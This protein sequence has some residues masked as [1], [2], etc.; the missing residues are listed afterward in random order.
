MTI[1]ILW[2]IIGLL[3]IIAIHFG[4]LAWLNPSIELETLI[5]VFFTAAYGFYV[6]YLFVEP[7]LRK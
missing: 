2:R 7:L 3:V 1:R 6:Y 4:L 5:I